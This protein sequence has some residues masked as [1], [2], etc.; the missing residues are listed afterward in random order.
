MT[1]KE[2]VIA[3][4]NRKPNGIPIDFGSTGVTGMH[5]SCVAVLRDYY[6]LEKKP[7]RAHEPYQMLGLL[8]EDLLQVMGVDVQGMFPYETMFGSLTHLPTNPE[9]ISGEMG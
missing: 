1:S 3:S 4:L 2:R 6:G 7:V 8:E 5:I 9:D